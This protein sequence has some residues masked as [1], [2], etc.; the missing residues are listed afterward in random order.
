MIYI[1]ASND[2]RGQHIVY[3]FNNS[4]GKADAILKCNALL[5]VLPNNNLKISMVNNSYTNSIQSSQ[6]C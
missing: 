6:K 3:T 4:D 2:N 5:G 1:Y